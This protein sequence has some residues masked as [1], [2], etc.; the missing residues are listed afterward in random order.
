[1]WDVGCTMFDVLILTMYDE[2]GM[3][4]EVLEA[5]VICAAFGVSAFAMF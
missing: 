4:N 3:M 5:D 2:L 1:M